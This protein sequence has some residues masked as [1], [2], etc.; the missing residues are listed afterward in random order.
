MTEKK[1]EKIKEKKVKINEL[2]EENAADIE[3]IDKNS[4]ND[5]ND[6]EGRLRDEEKRITENKKPPSGLN[7][8]DFGKETK[9]L[10]G[11]DMS[12]YNT[13]EEEIEVTEK[14]ITSIPVEKPDKQLF[15]RVHSE[16]VAEVDIVYFAAE[17]GRAYL[18]HKTAIQYVIGFV[19]KVKLYPYITLKDNL[20]LL[21]ITQPKPG[22]KMQEWHLSREKMVVIGRKDWIQMKPKSEGAGYDAIKAK[23]KHD[24]PEWPDLTLTEILEIAFMDYI[25]RDKNHPVVKA[26]QGA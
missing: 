6:F 23:K 15:A 21:P 26:L 1:E 25:I 17:K 10:S 16:M 3:T 22:K 20:G 11:F 13:P 12:E 14:I 19:S 7:M 8:A 5:F 2:K 9:E 4:D 24:N 18:I